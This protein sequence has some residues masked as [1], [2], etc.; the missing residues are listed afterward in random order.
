VTQRLAIA[1]GLGLAWAWA[2]GCGG[3]DG[4]SQPDAG[5]DCDV[6]PGTG[7][8]MPATGLCKHL[9]SYRIFDDLPAQAA[10][11]ALHPFDLATPLFS[12][13]T[14]KHRWLYVPAGATIA[15]HDTDAFDLPVGSMLVKTFA[16]PTDRRAPAAGRQLLETRLLL[17]QATGWTAG[18]YVYGDDPADADLKIAGATIDASWI[19][20]DGAA[21]TNRYVVPNTNQCINCHGEHSDAMTP[22]GP[23]ARHLNRDAVDGSGNQLTGLISAGIL[24][25][26][27]IDP[28]GW[29]RDPALEDQTASLEA[30]ARTWLD[31]N[32][33]HCHNP[34][35]A[36]RTSGLDLS[37]DQPDP[38]LYGVCKTPVA[39]GPG[40]GSLLYD[41]VPGKPADSI[42]AFR[43][44][45]TAPEIRMPEL[46]R[47]LVH[48]EGLALIEAWISAMP[49]VDCN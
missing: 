27:P 15:W 1:V 20:D 21:R 17:H 44:A 39:A 36:A 12:D 4:A 5:V 42:L 40:S 48:A 47:N 41:I 49:A 3:D 7:P 31:I 43:I 28:T 37:I 33:A 45:G 11:A 35:G 18:T 38:G 25:G 29:P 14:D 46:G 23:K 22:L 10:A 8:T 19:H 24:V 16:Y 13:Y 9:S 6:P 2:A 26:A 30:R 32:C 34:R